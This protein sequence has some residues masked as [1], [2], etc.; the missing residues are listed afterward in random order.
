[1]SYK[2]LLNDEICEE[3]EECKKLEMGSEVY[4]SSINGLCKLMD[5]QLEIEKLELQKEQQRIENEQKLFDN[6]IKAEQLKSDKRDKA[7]KNT[8]TG[9]SVIGGLGITIW[10]TIQAIKFE[11]NGSFTSLV[12]RGFIN[13]ITKL[14]KK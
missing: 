6:E 4:N 14:F 10:G 12:G 5:K 2:T 7:V 13:N 3:L 1:M 9:V 11:E 8:L